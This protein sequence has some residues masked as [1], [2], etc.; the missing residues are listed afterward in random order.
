MEK[1]DEIYGV[2]NIMLLPDREEPKLVSMQLYYSFEEAMDR[3]EEIIEE[4]IDDYGEDYIEHATRKRPVAIMDNG[5]VTGYVY[6]IE[7]NAV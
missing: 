5:E 7:T 4:F 2:V 3:S 1:K 6:I